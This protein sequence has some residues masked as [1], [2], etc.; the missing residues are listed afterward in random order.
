ME[1]KLDEAR[2]EADKWLEGREGGIA[3]RTSKNYRLALGGF[4]DWLEGRGRKELDSKAAAAWAKSL[5]DDVE[6][7]KTRP[8]TANLKI[9]CVNKC[10]GHLADVA[11]DAP[12]KL[13]RI[14]V[15]RAAALENVIDMEDYKKLLKACDAAGKER[16]RLIMETLANTGIRISEL[17]FFT[18]EAL[19]SGK[20]VTVSNKGKTR[21]VAVPD[22][23]RGK[24]LEYA[25]ENGI[26]GI[27]FHGRDRN[28]PLGSATI[29]KHFRKIAEAAGV[30]PQKVHPHSF[31]HFCGKTLEQNGIPLSEIQRTL[32]HSSP[33]TTAMYYTLPTEKEAQMLA[34]RRAAYFE[35]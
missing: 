28:K 4:F 2:R 24:L 5:K 6:A 18:V 13:K 25:E 21:K 31:R 7:G 1:I 3:G 9:V 35:V 23:M 16:E 33:N 14:K 15:E 17:G 29:R 26:T 8:G 20:P 19:K 10:L 30:D 12:I 34:N 27:V 11:G 22:S 32:G